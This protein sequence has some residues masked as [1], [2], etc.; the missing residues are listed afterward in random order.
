MDK[1]K[2]NRQ[3]FAQVELQLKFAFEIWTHD[4]SIKNTIR[5]NTEYSYFEKKGELNF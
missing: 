3:N 2:I 5:L 4:S 1:L